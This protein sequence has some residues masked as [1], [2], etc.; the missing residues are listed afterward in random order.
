MAVS[1]EGYKA[2]CGTV[3]GQRLASGQKAPPGDL[4]TTAQGGK[5]M[6]AIPGDLLLGP[7]LPAAVATEP[8]LFGESIKGPVPRKLS[9]RVGHIDQVV[10]DQLYSV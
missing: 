7:L 6:A 8:D 10:V 1:A 2:A 5:T 3:G 9:P 4:G